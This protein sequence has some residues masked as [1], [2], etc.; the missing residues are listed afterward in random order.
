MTG[1]TAALRRQGDVA[2]GNVVGSNIFNILG[3]LGVKAQIAL[4]D[5]WVMLGATALLVLCAMTDWRLSRREGAVF[6]TGY[7][8]YLV[9]LLA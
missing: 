6:P 5:I 2:F 7:V 1:V 3:I 9:V 4:Q 8:V